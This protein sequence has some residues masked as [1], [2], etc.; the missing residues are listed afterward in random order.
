MP[1]LRSY[2]HPGWAASAAVATVVALLV[3]VA[4]ATGNGQSL[5]VAGS[6]GFDSSCEIGVPGQ[7]PRWCSVTIWG[8]GAP[9]GWSLS[10]APGDASRAWVHPTTTT[11]PGS[12]SWSMTVDYACR[13]VGTTDITVTAVSVRNDRLAAHAGTLN[14]T[15]GPRAPLAITDGSAS[16]QRCAP[17]QTCSATMRGYGLYEGER[18]QWETVWFPSARRAV[19]AVGDI[20]GS[21]DGSWQATADY[22]CPT[23]AEASNEYS[24]WG[25][26]HVYLGLRGQASPV[27]LT[28]RP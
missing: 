5:T 19:Q 18:A 21:E 8:S 6:S 16:L 1:H 14:C 24:R 2:V 13:Q 26:T 17:G 9:A 4:V 23:L 20:D 15:A 11:G 28:C 12:S 10:A 3:G 7:G 22:R 25:G 27:Q